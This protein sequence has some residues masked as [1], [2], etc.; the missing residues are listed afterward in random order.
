MLHISYVSYI[1]RINIYIY[2]ICIC[3]YI[4]NIYISNVYLVQYGSCFP[5]LSYITVYYYFTRLKTPEI[6]RQNMK[7]GCSSSC[8]YYLLLILLY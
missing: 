3:I 4:Y 5:C 7:F 6:S 8:L 2:I 1:I